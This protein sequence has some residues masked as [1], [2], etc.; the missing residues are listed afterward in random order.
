MITMIT[1]GVTMK[2]KKNAV[3]TFRTEDWIKDQLQL[4]AD[5]FEWSLAQMVEKICKK[6]VACPAP[7]HIIIKTTDLINAVEE[8]KSENTTGAVEILITLRENE[9]KTDVEKILTYSILENGGAGC[10]ADFEAI[11]EMKPEEIEEIP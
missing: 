7:E 11:A 1:G 9:D 8:I 6:Y 2:E 4:A 5:K 10:I 3:I